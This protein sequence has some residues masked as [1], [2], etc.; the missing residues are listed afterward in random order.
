MTHHTIGLAI[1]ESKMLGQGKTKNIVFIQGVHHRA[2]HQ[3]LTFLI[4][5]KYTK[6]LMKTLV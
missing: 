1:L 3:A 4:Q 6:F 5:D 2:V